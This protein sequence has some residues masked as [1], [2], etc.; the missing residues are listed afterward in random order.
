MEYEITYLDTD[1]SG[2]VSHARG[3]LTLVE[4]AGKVVEIV[5]EEADGTAT[6]IPASRVIGWE[7]LA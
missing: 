5:I 6:F 7:R 2:G 1:Q 3:P 4:R